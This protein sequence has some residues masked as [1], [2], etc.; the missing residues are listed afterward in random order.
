MDNI[1]IV[2]KRLRE[3]P[4]D[5]MDPMDPMDPYETRCFQDPVYTPE[6]ATKKEE[7]EGPEKPVGPQEPD[8]Q[9]AEGP[10]DFEDIEEPSL[11][12]FYK[13]FVSRTPAQCVQE[14]CAPQRSIL[15]LQARKYCITASNF[16]AAAG[17]NSYM[18]P[19]QLVADKI[20]SCFKGN[21][22][23]AF[24]TFHE[25][26]ASQSLEKLLASSLQASLESLWT[27][28]KK[29]GPFKWR[30]HEVGLLKWHKKPWLAVSPDGL[31]ELYSDTE[32]LWILVEYKCPARQRDS[33]SHP[34]AKYS[35][36]I[37]DYYMDQ[38]QGVMGLLNE[39]PAIMP[40]MFSGPLHCLFVV[41]QKHQLHVTL[42]PFER[43]YYT[44]SLEPALRSWYFK[45]YLPRA[46]LK[47]TGSLVEGTL[48]A[49]SDIHIADINKP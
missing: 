45:K 22:F 25:K 27:S 29:T 18:S 36:N 3:D 4:M 47:H 30:L 46:Y 13:T 41:W 19:D 17:H 11:K 48:I 35:N 7:P 12:T 10:E 38:I 21:A 40:G 37:P 14:S 1:Q 16:G 33:D 23:T 32:N 26:D 15:W 24:G 28:S 43:A 34:Y 2:K 31:L 49:G 5:L 44:D 20:W 6:D 39:S 42:V 9:E 8:G